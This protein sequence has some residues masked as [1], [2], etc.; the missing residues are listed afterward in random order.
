MARAH[1]AEVITR[2]AELSGD[3]ASSESCL[4][5]AL[6]VLKGTEGTDPDLVV[7]LQPTSPMREPDEIARALDTLEREGADSLFSA[8]RVEGFIWRVEPDGA[9][10]SFSYD[11]QNR[12]RRQDAPEDLVENG[13]IYIFKPW[14]LRQFG[15]RLGGKIAVH[16]MSLV[17]SLQIDEPADL[18]LA[19]SIMR[20]WH[21]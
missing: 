9:V 18:D 7:F 15:N 17:Q 1:G 2:P 14:V 3:T 10:R 21:R 16:R 8:S 11:H 13:S 19:D 12:P 5:H 6:D 4:V 20:V